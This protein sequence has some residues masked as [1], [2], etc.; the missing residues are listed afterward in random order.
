MASSL[1][2]LSYYLLLVLPQLHYYKFST[3]PTRK[4]IKT[5]RS[6]LCEYGV[7][8]RTKYP[9]GKISSQKWKK[10]KY[11]SNEPKQNTNKW[12]II[13]VSNSTKEHADKSGNHPDL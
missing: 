9:G 4:G 3:T 11:Q 12:Q 10:V 2:L 7:P 6:T 5:S 13:E 8:L 1:N